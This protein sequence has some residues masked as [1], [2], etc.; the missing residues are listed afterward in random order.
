[1][2]IHAS[3][4][5][6]L[7]VGTFDTK[8]D[9]LM[10]MAELLRK[11]GVPTQTVDV[12]TRVQAAQ[13]ADIGNLEVAQFH[14]NGPSAVF[15]GDRGRAIA[16]MAL[17]LQ[18]YALHRLQNEPFAGVLCA[19]GS[20]AANLASPM[21]QCLPVGMPK[22][23]VSTMAAGDVSAYVGDSDIFTLYP[24]ADVSGLNRI[25][26]LVLGNAALALAGMLHPTAASAPHT[27]DKPAI[28]LTMFGVTTPCVQAVTQ[29]LQQEFDCIVFH[30]TGVG[31][32]AMEKLVESGMI[33]AVVDLTTTEIADEVVGGV[34]SAGPQ[35]L[36]VFARMAVPYV[37][38]L[39]ALDVINF[40]APESVPEVFAQR[41]LVAHN[42]Q[43]TLM[44]SNET[45]CEAIGQ[46]LVGKINAMRGPARLLLPLR[47]LSSLDAPGQPFFLPPA[48]QSLFAAIERNFA[49][50]PEHRMVRLD[51]H[52]N[53]PAFAASVV[54]HVREL[55]A[56]P[57]SHE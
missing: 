12:S 22:I 49:E 46:W 16:Q 9:E 8:K 28:A 26:R 20:G 29:A 34:L 35:R 41:T 30:A 48:N 37:G 24:I 14:P 1:M 27:N 2:L 54:Q 18:H 21:L 40:W 32:R 19:G 56:S 50:H 25:S 43:V 39:G 38:S 42:P 17:A 47:G 55:V 51:M 13:G 33:K 23:L 52:L 4:R 11:Q 5:L 15:T 10:Y 53:E 7:V 44:R 45:E 36:D 57:R 6:A 31:G 3:S